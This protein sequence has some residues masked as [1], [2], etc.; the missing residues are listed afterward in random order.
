MPTLPLY[1]ELGIEVLLRGHAGELMH[2]YKA[3][4]YSLDAASLGIA[5]APK[6]EDWLFQRLRA[7]MVEGVER[8]FLAPHLWNDLEALARESLH[9]DVE[10]AA[11]PGP[12]AQRIWRLFVSQRLRR[13]TVL[14]MN[15]FRSVVETRLP[16]QD[17]DLISLLLAAPADLKL[18]EEIQL[19]LLRR[20]RPEFLRVKNANTATKVGAGPMRRNL[21]SLA[22]RVAAKLGLPGYLPYE[23]LGLWLRRELRD[24]VRGVLLDP[25]TLDRGLYDADGVRQLVENH[26][27]EGR[28]HTYAIMGLMIF[29]LG[30]RYLLDE[31]SAQDRDSMPALAAA[32][33]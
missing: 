2:M 32:G 18:G 8:P 1:R 10:A 4:N 17:N 9:A 3:Y 30:Q 26:G 14:S 6:L 24:V 31:T 11:A 12:P 15:E 13:E 23:R 29:E 27:K 28:N 33:K 5:S 19:A 22:L 7:Y 16:L 25:R 20:F 21:S